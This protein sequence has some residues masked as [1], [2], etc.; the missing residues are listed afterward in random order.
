MATDWFE[1]FWVMCVTVQLTQIMARLACVTFRLSKVTLTVTHA[2]IWSSYVAV[3]YRM[4]RF[5]C[6]I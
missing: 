6:G 4:L 1:A 2:T 5:G 3:R